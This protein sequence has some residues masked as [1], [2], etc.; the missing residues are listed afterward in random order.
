MTRSLRNLVW[1]P[2]VL[3]LLA[4]PLTA[5][6]LNTYLSGPHFNLNV[7]G[8][9]EGKTAAMTNSSRHTI[10]VGLGRKNTPV[11]T[12][13]WLQPGT[14]HFRVCDGNGFD[15]AHDCA[16][17]AFKEQGARCSSCPATRH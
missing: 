14:L 17:V 5:Q 11:T 12:R 2:V 16:G 13:I 4:A 8:V 1:T 3:V 15:A 7:I 10:F 9:D 6:N